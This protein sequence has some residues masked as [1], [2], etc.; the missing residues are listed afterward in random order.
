VTG[1][2]QAYREVGQCVA[3][4]YPGALCLMS[5]HLA[6]LMHT[7]ELTETT[8]LTAASELLAK[9]AKD[10]WELVSGTAVLNPHGATTYI[11]YWKRDVKGKGEMVIP[12]D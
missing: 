10:S 4:E 5:C 9:R 2:R 7:Y 1:G 3:T 12:M 6:F 8:G 11:Q